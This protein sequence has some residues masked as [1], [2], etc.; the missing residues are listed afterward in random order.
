MLPFWLILAFS[1]VIAVGSGKK[2]IP[3]D[4]R[5]GL[6]ARPLA[7]AW[8]AEHGQPCGY[9]AQ[10]GDD[11]YGLTGPGRLLAQGDPRG[12]AYL[13]T[14]KVTV[15]LVP[16][17]LLAACEHTAPDFQ[18]FS[19]NP[20]GTSIILLNRDR[21]PTDADKAAAL[22]HELVHVRYGEGREPAAH[23]S[24]L[25]QLWLSEEGE[26]HRR[27]LETKETLGAQGLPSRIQEDL[28]YIY[29]LQLHVILAV[30]P[31]IVAAGFLLL[32]AWKRQNA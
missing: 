12:Y 32:A 3:D 28:N 11:A 27:G 17:K 9:L 20:V 15:A 10:G 13:T 5:K 24:L 26:A 16:G 29:A 2:L 14:H 1:V 18:N 6:Y 19:A 7:A 30:S 22:S 4:L 31:V 25:S 8:V 23:R 21:L